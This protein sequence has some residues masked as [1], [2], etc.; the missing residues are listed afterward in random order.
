MNHFFSFLTTAASGM[1]RRILL[2]VA[3]VA[4]TGAMAEYKLQSGD[5][6][7]ISV[8]GVPDLRQRSQI[9]L[10]GDVALPLVGQIKV[11]GISVSEARAKITQSLS[12]RLYQQSTIDGREIQHLVLPETIV[13]TVAEYRPIYVSGDVAKPGEYVFRPGMTVRQAI[14]VAGGY[15]LIQPRVADPFLQTADFRSENQALWAEFATEQA[16]IWRLR[17]ELGQQGVEYTGNKA[18][19]PAELAGRLL[20][21]ANEQLKAHVAAREQDKALLQEAV[22][23][24]NAQLSILAAK[25]K[26]DQEGNQADTADFEKARDLAQRGLTLAARLSDA[27]RSALLSA[28]QLLQTVVEMS[29][30]E[31]QRDEYTRQLEKIDSDAR[32]NA[33]RELQEANL[34]VAQ[35]TA[36]LQSTGDKLMYTGLQSQFTQGMDRTPNITVYRDG[37][38][39][40][41]RLT[42]DENLELAPGDVVDVTLETKSSA[43]GPMLSKSGG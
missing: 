24:A 29:N 22:A 39:G 34:R 40:R 38:K 31:R 32:I 25:K 30:I 18:P 4:P 10:D 1:S 36:R 5:T 26:N 27:R 43:K 9:G 16:R 37:E 42:A 14:A 41:E 19:I 17:T 21:T 3:L 28:D 13:V 8:T 11:S 35:I 15:G 6:L 33:L 7:E 20:Q 2:V 23:K 12:N